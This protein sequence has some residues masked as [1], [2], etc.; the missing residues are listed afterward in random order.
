MGAKSR[1]GR[2]SFQGFTLIEL[3]VVIA[4]I[5]I[6][7]AILFPVF[8]RARE[9]ARKSSCQSNLKQ[10]ALG[11]M[12]YTQD[13]DEMNPYMQWTN[14]GNTILGRNPVDSLMP[15][16]KSNQVW[17]CPSTNNNTL[18]NVGLWTNTNCTATDGFCNHSG[19]KIGYA[20]NE[21]A[22]VPRALSDCSNPAV[23]YLLLD[24]GNNMTITAWYGWDTRA[25]D[26]YNGNSV[27]GPHLDGKNV[28][29]VDGHVKW[30]LSTNIRARDLNPTT[31][32][33]YDAT[34]PYYGYYKN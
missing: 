20:W 7:A 14:N 16:I 13:Y 2:R 27:V 15:Y 29:Y 23:T 1:T 26:T 8:A 19:E 17:V 25:Q 9:N 24:K 10:I 3:L 33:G 21:D 5:A 18:G 4:I 30:A 28:A 12:Q 11:W 34:S 6:L 22:I 32:I 31:L